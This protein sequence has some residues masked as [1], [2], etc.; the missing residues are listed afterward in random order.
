MGKVIWFPVVAFL[1]LGGQALADTPKGA[2][3]AVS[4]KPAQA[5]GAAG[6]GLG[7]ML[8]GAK[9]GL[10]Q[11]LAATTNGSFGTQTFGISTGTSNCETAPG[12]S[13]STKVF[14]AANRETLSKDIARGSGETITNLSVLAGCQNAAAVGATLQKS[15]QV[16]FPNASVSDDVVGSNVVTVLASDKT[17]ACGNLT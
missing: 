13:A 10:I 1:C 12:G 7:S 5:Y 9:P 4:V 14:V 6:C 2:Q 16:I 3:V 15:F 11:V 17:L 8:F